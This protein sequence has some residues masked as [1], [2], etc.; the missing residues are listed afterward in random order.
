MSQT[1]YDAEELRQ[2]MADVEKHLNAAQDRCNFYRDNDYPEET[3]E[4]LTKLLYEIEAVRLLVH[5]VIRALEESNDK[6]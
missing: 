4:P 2:R 1:K 3:I 5:P 6:D